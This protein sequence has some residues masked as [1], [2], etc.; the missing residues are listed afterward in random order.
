LLDDPL[1]APTADPHFADDLPDFPPPK[2]QSTAKPPTHPK[3][4]FPRESPKG[5][6]RDLENE[7]TPGNGQNLVDLSTVL[8]AVGASQPP[9]FTRFGRSATSAA[10]VWLACT[11]VHFA[12]HDTKALAKVCHLSV[13]RFR[14]LRR[15]MSEAI[16][17]YWAGDLSAHQEAFNEALVASMKVVGQE[18]ARDRKL[19]AQLTGRLLD[20]RLEELRRADRANADQRQGL[21]DPL[22]TAL[23]RARA[24]RRTQDVVIDAEFETKEGGHHG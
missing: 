24:A 7:L 6:Q 22:A 9:D 10:R 15:Q 3:L 11:S 14:D 12:K 23:D 17:S 18:G 8:P 21:G 20:P 1:F 19:F 16:G 13:N 5:I 4:S 2:T